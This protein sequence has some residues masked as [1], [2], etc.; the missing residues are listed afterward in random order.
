MSFSSITNEKIVYTKN[1]IQE[2]K[3]NKENLFVIEERKYEKLQATVQKLE[4][5]IKNQK[6]V[7]DSLNEF[8]KDKELENENL[9][10]LFIEAKEENDFLNPE[11]QN[12]KIQN[13]QLSERIQALI[14]EIQLLENQ[15]K[16]LEGWNDQSIDKLRKKIQDLTTRTNDLNNENQK[17]SK[18]VKKLIKKNNVLRREKNFNDELNQNNYHSSKRKECFCSI[19]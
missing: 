15:K 1:T 4:K 19:L 11:N 18:H 5:K 17:L 2:T 3:Q 12:L 14:K 13:Q 6:E 9:Y 8:L 10:N 7:I 16:Y